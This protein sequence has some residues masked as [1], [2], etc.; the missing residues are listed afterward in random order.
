VS[1]QDWILDMFKRSLDSS[2]RQRATS[3]VFREYHSS[4]LVNLHDGLGP[5][6]FCM[7]VR[8]GERLSFSQKIGLERKCPSVW[9][10]DSMP[11]EVA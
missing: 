6:K 7:H 1:V 11:L 10:D 2:V 8:G 9:L 4:H 3:I 5:S